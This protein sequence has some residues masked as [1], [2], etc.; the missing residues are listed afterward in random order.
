MLQPFTGA[1]IKKDPPLYWYKVEVPYSEAIP[2]SHG[3]HVSNSFTLNLLFIVY[4]IRDLVANTS[5]AVDKSLIIYSLIYHNYLLVIYLSI[6]SFFSNFHWWHWVLLI[7]T[8]ESYWK[9]SGNLDSNPDGGI[10]CS[11]DKG[12]SFGNAKY[13]DLQIW[14]KDEKGYL[15]LCYGFRRPESVDKNKYFTGSNGFE[16][17][18]LEVYEI[19]F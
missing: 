17:T 8:G 13:C 19:M 14:C 15:D 9:P 16:I 4:G 2:Q 3:L 5:V 12:P 18:D 11:S 7:H 6:I 10:R 1:V